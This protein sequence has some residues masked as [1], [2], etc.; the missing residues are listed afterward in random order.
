MLGVFTDTSSRVGGAEQ[1]IRN[2]FKGERVKIFSSNL[3]KLMNIK[4]TSYDNEIKYNFNWFNWPLTLRNLRKRI[5]QHEINKALINLTIGPIGIGGSLFVKKRIVNFHTDIEF[6]EKAIPRVFRGII[7]RS[8]KI[9]CQKATELITPSKRTRE[10]LINNNWHDKVTV[11]SPGVDMKL[12]KKDVKKRKLT[13]QRLGV[14]DDEFLMIDVSRLTL[15]KNLPELIKTANKL[16][17]KKVKLLLVGEG[18][19]EKMLKEIAG[20]NV[21]FQGFVPH[22]ELVNYYNAADLMTHPSSTESL[23]LSMAEAM[24]CKVPV[25]S[26]KS[27]GAMDLVKGAGVIYKDLEKEVLRLLDDDKE[28]KRIGRKCH[29]RI[30]KEHDLE[31]AKAKIKKVINNL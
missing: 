20:S 29:S 1:S 30:K 21:I 6:I 11:V 28:R 16:V 12:F 18:K 25:I 10:F 9:I 22:E 23:G 19:E 2:W 17:N 13:R 7:R 5:K 24:A 27:K 8:L 15:D 4:S 3:E 14:K 26:N 31:K